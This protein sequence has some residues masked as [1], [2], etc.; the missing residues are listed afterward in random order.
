[1]MRLQP[2]QVDKELSFDLTCPGIDVGRFVV[3]VSPR[4]KGIKITVWHHSS[5]AP[6]YNEVISGF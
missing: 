4:L 1:M 5:L 6:W 2:E 3:E